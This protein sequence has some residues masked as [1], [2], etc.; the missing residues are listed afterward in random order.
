EYHWREAGESR[1]LHYNRTG[2]DF[3]LVAPIEFFMDQA[4]R[5]TQH[6]I[7][8]NDPKKHRDDYWVRLGGVE[9]TESMREPIAWQ[10][11]ITSTVHRDVA[12][13]ES[14][15]KG[16]TV[17]TTQSHTSSNTFSAELS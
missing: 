14:Q 8:L 5:K 12:Q 4:K 1:Q 13:E 3:M 11:Q 16:K 17:S 7:P 10:I 9:F 6:D 15:T 2:L